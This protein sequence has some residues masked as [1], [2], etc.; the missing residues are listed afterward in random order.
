MK[1]LEERIILGHQERSSD[2]DWGSCFRCGRPW[3]NIHGHNTAYG[4]KGFGCFPLCEDCWSEL[5]PEER[6]PYYRALYDSWTP[7][8]QDDWNEIEQAVMAGK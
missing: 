4:S 3:K 8:C 1:T 5:T 6:L 7:D 2:P